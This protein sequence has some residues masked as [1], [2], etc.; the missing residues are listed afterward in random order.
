MGSD[1]NQLLSVGSYGSWSQYECDVISQE[2]IML[3]FVNDDDDYGNCSSERV[4]SI[5]KMLFVESLN[6]ARDL[7]AKAPA[8]APMV[9]LQ[10]SSRR[11]TS[12][13]DF[14]TDFLKARSVRC[15]VQ[16]VLQAA[17]CG[18]VGPGDGA[19]SNGT[20]FWIVPK[21]FSTAEPAAVQANC[22]ISAQCREHELPQR[23]GQQQREPHFAGAA[24]RVWPKRSEQFR[25]AARGCAFAWRLKLF[26]NCALPGQ[27]RTRSGGSKSE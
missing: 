11:P 5:Y 20:A 15:S 26:K 14:P 4:F 27:T 9:L 13:T 1:I 7:L 22:A 16:P 6:D 25:A 3:F 19:Q 10:A 2:C 24:L 12:S 8:A 17:D 21:L 23:L 18:A